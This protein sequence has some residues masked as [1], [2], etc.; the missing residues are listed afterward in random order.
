MKPAALLLALAAGTAVAADP[1]VG[2]KGTFTVCKETTYVTGPLDADGRIDYVAALND[3]LAKGVTPDSNA[4]ALLW[5]ALGPK[6]EGY[7]VEAAYFKRLAIPAP[8][9]RGDYFV[10]STTFFKARLKVDRADDGVK[11]LYEQE[12]AAHLRPWKADEFP[13]VADWLAA[14]DKPLAVVAEAA[15][16]PVYF[17]PVAPHMTKDGP[18]GIL[19]THSYGLVACRSV[20]NALT[21][22]A[23]LRI[24]KG[25]AAGA[26]AD[27]LTGLRLGRHIARGGHH[28][29]DLLVG[30]VL[31][32]V[33]ART[34]VA[35]LDRAELD[36]K[37]LAACRRDLDG[38]P[39]PPDLAERADV[40]DRFFFLDTV[41]VFDRGIAKSMDALGGDKDIEA[42]LRT[43]KVF[44]WDPT[45]RAANAFHDRMATALRHPDRANRVRAVK[46]LLDELND[47]AKFDAE[48]KAVAD[49]VAGG[50]NPS[51]AVSRAVGN[52]VRGQL[53]SAW[54][55]LHDA[56]DRQRQGHANLQVAFALAAYK[57]DHGRYPEALAALAPKYLPTVPGDLFS[58]KELVYR[59]AA[60]GYVLYSVGPN[61]KDDG[62]RG[63][64]DD[65]AG[66][67]VV[68]RVP[69]AAK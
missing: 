18:S 44:D 20:V 65:P 6:P 45:L 58:G 14:N 31:E 16:R 53:V 52:I 63:R 22:R 49:A 36:A 41:M 34:T 69:V 66:D 3:R 68:V 30:G 19:G 37:Q 60:G 57:L 56:A 59:P 33:A 5:K 55:K 46:H 21:A 43:T 9:E 48:L 13:A 2:L 1:P 7:A 47:R 67:D 50:H 62:G 39:P 29:I 17:S 12:E 27:L 51:E 61:G 24:G 64:D 4:M 23:M 28:H 40:H 10:N 11:K 42:L 15:R 54:D 26:W 8:P 25:D 32:S 38:L 35:F